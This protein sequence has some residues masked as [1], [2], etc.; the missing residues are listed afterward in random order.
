MALNRPPG[1]VPIHMQT[2]DNWDLIGVHDLNRV[3]DL[4]PDKIVTQCPPK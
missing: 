1:P 3:R 4:K 2:Q